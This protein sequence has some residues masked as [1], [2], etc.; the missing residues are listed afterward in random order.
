MSTLF[1]MSAVLAGALAA[2]IIVAVIE[3][4]AERIAPT[5][6][7]EAVIKIISLIACL[8]IIGAMIT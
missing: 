2:A 6:T 7:Q 5:S 4:V 1:F 3:L 8:I